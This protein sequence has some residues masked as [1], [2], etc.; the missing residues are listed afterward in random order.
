MV[1][2]S[3]DHV[4]MARILMVTEE[5]PSTDVISAVVSLSDDLHKPEVL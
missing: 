2:I 5:L 3:E 1:F 4:N